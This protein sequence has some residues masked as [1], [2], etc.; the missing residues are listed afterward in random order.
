MFTWTAGAII[1]VIALVTAPASDQIKV[2]N[3]P[4]VEAQVSAQWVL[5]RADR[6]AVGIVTR[7]AACPD[8]VY[9]FA[10]A[11]NTIY[12]VDLKQPA[13]RI[14]LGPEV[15]GTI[16][17][18]PGELVNM[19]VDC[20]TGQLSV[21]ANLLNKDRSKFIATFDPVTR[22]VIRTFELPS[23]FAPGVS[24][25]PL[26]DAVNRRV[27]LPGIWP[28]TRNGWLTKP[29]ESALTDA[30]FGLM[31][32]LDN[33]R[34]GKLLLPGSDAGCRAWVGH[35]LESFFAQNQ[36]DEWVFAH[37]LGTQLSVI[38]PG[39][40]VTTLDMRSPMFRVVAADSVPRP[41]PREQGMAW[42]YRN[43][44][45]RG[46]YL[47]DQYIVA[48]H[49]HHSTEK[50][51]AGGWV[52]FTAYLNVFNQ[53]GDRVY[54]DLRLSGLP[55]GAS[56]DAVWVASYRPARNDQA[57]EMVLQKVLPR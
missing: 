22:Q 46:V 2:A 47:I 35:C 50:A 37:G 45:I 38:R 6:K 19:F 26:Y 36:P 28:S 7:A 4:P 57:T 24:A 21:V 49:A 12:S 5:S 55:I 1:A 16:A 40:T 42:A 48:A 56:S 14:A 31:L 33:G 15:L 44:Q 51:T 52:D 25:S 18:N 9:L 3:G 20:R 32:S 23:E 54:S 30:T 11:R 34:A 29:V 43:S 41:A 17:K 10:V 13:L 39:K 53:K 27:F 8:R